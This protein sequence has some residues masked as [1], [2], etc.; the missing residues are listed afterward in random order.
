MKI[1]RGF[2]DIQLIARKTTYN[3]SRCYAENLTLQKK[4]TDN[5]LAVITGCMVKIQ[6]A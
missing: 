5:T 1:K 6:A 2:P 3:I 4:C